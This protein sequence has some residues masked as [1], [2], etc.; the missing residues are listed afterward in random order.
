MTSSLL[1]ADRIRATIKRMFSGTHAEVLAELFQNAQRVKATEVAFRTA[2]VDGA[3]VL[4]YSD[5]GPGLADAEAYFKLLAIGASAYDAVTEQVQNPMGFGFNALLAHEDVREVVVRSGGLSLAI[6]AVRW[7]ADGPYAESWRERLV[8][9]SMQPGLQLEVHFKA[10]A[11]QSSWETFDVQIARHIKHQA[12]SY[13]GYFQV[14][15]NGVEVA[16]KLDEAFDAASTNRVAFHW[17]GQLEDGTALRWIKHKNWEPN[18][19]FVRWY[20]QL[21]SDRLSLPQLEGWA[22]YLDVTHGQPVDLLAPTRKSVI[23]NDKFKA[24]LA[25][26]QQIL[27]DALNQRAELEPYMVK[28]LKG[29]SLSRFNAESQ[30]G[31]VTVWEADK[32]PATSMYDRDCCAKERVLTRAEFKALRAQNLVFKLCSYV[33]RVGS[34]GYENSYRSG[35]GSF[36]PFAD[37]KLLLVFEDSLPEHW[38]E[39]PELRCFWKSGLLADRQPEQGFTLYEPGGVAW[40]VG[41]GLPDE[42]AYQPLPRQ[43]H[44]HVCDDSGSNNLEELDVMVGTHS[45]E[46]YLETYQASWV[47]GE[48]QEKLRLTDQLMA[49]RRSFRGNTVSAAFTLQDLHKFLEPEEFVL[50]LKLNY[51]KLAAPVARPVPT[52]VTVTTSQ[53]RKLKLEFYA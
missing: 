26:A 4:H 15:L 9:C 18:N 25:E 23:R 35:L 6:D 21:V 10:E 30:H 42:L 53:G 39:L 46:S 31:L 24:V 41:D 32:L 2:M 12:A 51:A 17:D 7:W 29:L 27:F 34:C 1:V 22:L 37:P 3:A 33:S 36:L 5:N 52:S 49:L 44:V 40:H 19:L 14:R 28:A 45:F 48:E 47:I 16:Q 20:G 11:S 38:G 8:P 50:S 43:V 13:Y